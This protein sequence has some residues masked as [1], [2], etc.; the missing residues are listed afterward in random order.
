MVPIFIVPLDWVIFDLDP[1]HLHDI[2]SAIYK[3]LNC[4]P[5]PP[6]RKEQKQKQKQTNKD[7]NK[8]KTATTEARERRTKFLSAWLSGQGWKM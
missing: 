7:P 1:L 2:R 6:P 8:D 3:L 4:S 5:P